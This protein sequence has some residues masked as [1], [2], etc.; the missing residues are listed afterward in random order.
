[1]LFFALFFGIIGGVLGLILTIAGIF[2]HIMGMTIAGASFLVIFPCI[3]FLVMIPEIKEKKIYNKIVEN[4]RKI[5]AKIVGYEKEDGETK[6]IC[7]CYYDWD[8]RKFLV[9]TQNEDM[10]NFTIGDMVTLA[11][12]DKDIVYIKGSHRK[13]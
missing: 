11:T 4:G 8:I 9:S 10:K 7:E 3:G 6:I 12:N 2:S 1:M 13:A 5:D